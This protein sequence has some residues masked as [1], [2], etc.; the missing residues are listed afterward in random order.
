MS[1]PL[2]GLNVVH[3]PQSPPTESSGQELLST[4]PGFPDLAAQLDLWTNLNF[5]SDEPFIDTHGREED[6]ASIQF[7][8]SGLIASLNSPHMKRNLIPTPDKPIHPVAGIESPSNH[9]S[10][11]MSNGISPS[12]DLGSFLSGLG[13]DP[14]LVPP[15]PSLDS[16]LTSI[17]P[18]S[19]SSRGD[20]SAILTTN[21]GADL[22]AQP[23]SKRTRTSKS[24]VSL[25]AVPRAVSEFSDDHDPLSTPLTAS[26]D[27]RRRNTAASA[28]FRAKK[29]EREQAME[30]RSKDLENRVNE[31][32]RE[33]EGLRRENGWLKGLVVGVTSGNPSAVP[34][35]STEE[36]KP[37]ES[38]K[39]RKRESSGSAEE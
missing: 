22:D 35:P 18:S 34:P 27:K 1:N 21:S 39:K 36:V 26:E 25:P 24:S 15:Q 30:R 3:P 32:E 33:C 12:F 6:I 29:K 38:N 28:R 8:D 14:F 31:L 16:D 11:H 4:P 37:Q 7:P 20:L 2:E 13:I 17:P 9:Q 23:T 5:A 10:T 19:I